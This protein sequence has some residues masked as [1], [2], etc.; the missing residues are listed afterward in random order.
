MVS[1]LIWRVG[2]RSEGQGGSGSWGRRRGSP[3]LCSA[4]AGGRRRG[5]GAAG[6]GL[7]PGLA[8]GHERG[9]RNPLEWK[10]RCCGGRSRVHGVEAARR[11]GTSPAGGVRAVPALGSAGKGVCAH[12]QDATRPK[13]RPAGPI[14]QRRGARRGAAALGRRRAG[15]GPKGCTAAYTIMP[16][17]TSG[18]I[19]SS[20]SFGLKRRPAQSAR[21]RRPAAEVGRSLWRS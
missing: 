11:G 1:D 10:A 19:R 5:T 18:R 6:L 13:I 4:A 20:P 3:E 8:V 17:R 2:S 21:R 15:S 7:G 14:A 12:A 9:M 16:K